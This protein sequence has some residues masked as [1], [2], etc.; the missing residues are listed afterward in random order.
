MMKRYAVVVLVLAASGCMS[1]EETVQAARENARPAYVDVRLDEG[2][3]RVPAVL[4]AHPTRF[5]VHNRGDE[6]HNFKIEGNGA[7]IQL[8]NDLKPHQTRVVAIDLAPGE[9][10]VNCPLPGHDHQ[11]P[12][13]VMVGDFGA[14]SI[15]GGG[16][17][18]NE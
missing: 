10:T 15:T 9:Y 13:R 11:G 5:V 14:N 18:G 17:P 12:V 16:E 4:A 6:H 2:V 8:K 3:I 7:E 1:R